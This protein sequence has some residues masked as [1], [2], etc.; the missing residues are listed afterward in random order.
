MEKDGHETPFLHFWWPTFFLTLQVLQNVGA[1]CEK[2][3]FQGKVRHEIKIYHYL[4]YIQISKAIAKAI[5]R[6]HSIGRRCPIAEKLLI[7]ANEKLTETINGIMG[8]LIHCYIPP[9]LMQS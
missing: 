3:K 1:D 5:D 9:A 7:N 4:S 8:E 6:S 2:D